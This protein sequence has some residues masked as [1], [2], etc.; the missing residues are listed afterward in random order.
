MKMSIL[1]AAFAAFWASAINAAQIEWTINNGF[2]TDDGVATGSFVWDPNTLSAVSW[3]F[4][5]FGGTTTTWS[6]NTYSDAESG[7]SSVA[8]GSALL[9]VDT[10]NVENRR[11]DLRL[12]FSSLADLN[13]PV[14]ELL[15][16]PQDFSIGGLDENFNYVP[17]RTQ[18]SSGTAFLSADISPV[19]IPASLPLLAFGLGGL[20][21]LARRK[22]KAN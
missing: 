6:P 5:T 9:F 2:F 22:R 16:V 15:L 11:R 13:T 8:I 10:V 3:D 1:V 21:L 18:G 17:G 7:S 4:S 20:G 14:A 12:G 19:P